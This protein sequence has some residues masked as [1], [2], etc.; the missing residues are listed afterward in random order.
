MAIEFQCPT[1]GTD[2]RVSDAAAGKMVRC[3]QCLGTLRAPAAPAEDDIPY[4]EAAPPPEPP[5]APPEVEPVAPPPRPR[6]SRPRRRPIPRQ[7]G[8]PA[9][10]PDVGHAAG[11]APRA[12]PRRGVAAVRP[13]VHAAEIAQGYCRSDLQTKSNILSGISRRFR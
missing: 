6:S 11:E 9:H 4:A 7:K 10:G 8:S 2:L 3:G 1:C 13:A 12:G 5:A